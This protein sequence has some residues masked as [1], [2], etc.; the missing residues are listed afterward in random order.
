[1]QSWSLQMALYFIELEQI[2]LKNIWNHKRP[3]IVKEIFREKNKARDIL[4]PDFKLHCKAIQ[5]I[6][7]LAQKQAHRS[8]EQNR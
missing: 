5:N 7:V 2:I 6:M 4:V 1:M 3:R 8:I